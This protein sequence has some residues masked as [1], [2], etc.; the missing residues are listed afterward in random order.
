MDKPEFQKKLV[1][2][3]MST[4]GD[5]TAPVIANATGA[6]G[7]QLKRWLKELISEGALTTERNADNK[8][9]FCVPK[10][11]RAAQIKKLRA[12][13]AKRAAEAAAD[14]TDPPAAPSEPKPEPA[15]AKPSRGMKEA[16]KS[17]E[18]RPLTA[19]EME[20]LMALTAAVSKE[21][22]SKQ[23][24]EAEQ[25]RAAIAAKQAELA[26]AAA[27]LADAPEV[28][29]DEEP[30]PTPQLEAK[31]KAEAKRKRG[32]KKS[33]RKDKN[34]KAE[35]N[36]LDKLDTALAVY[37]AIDGKPANR[38]DAD[39]P[40][41]RGLLARLRGKVDAR[42]ALE[43]AGQAREELEQ[44]AEPHEKSILLSG[45][46]SLFMGPLGWNYAGSFRESIPAS[47][48]WLG[49][50]AVVF[51]LPILSFALLPAF[52]AGLAV[53][54]ILGMVYAWQFNKHGHRVRLLGDGEDKK[55]KD[56]K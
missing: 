22:E 39:K 3:W 21:V 55:D 16:E 44:P 30:P 36:A 29:L 24:K 50:A 25:R 46:L 32:K 43:L 42:D 14:D 8:L 41:K 18:D 33:K 45:G 26:E 40:K 47:V 49:V 56:D 20:K 23:D 52:I 31:A 48:V 5:L 27:A 6:T 15:P 4:D 12:L 1:R 9:T 54:G 38:D 53:S 51:K 19:A 17:L 7:P 37:D 2:L 11:P 28:N 13:K 35:P 34:K 10:K